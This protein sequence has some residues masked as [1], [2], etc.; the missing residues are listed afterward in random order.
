MGKS[1]D[2]I[3]QVIDTESSTLAGSSPK[4]KGIILGGT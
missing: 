1:P 3:R 2:E 4:S